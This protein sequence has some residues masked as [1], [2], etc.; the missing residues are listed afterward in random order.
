[1]TTNLRR[2]FRWAPNSS[3]K[4]LTFG[5][6][7]GWRRWSKNKQQLSRLANDAKAIDEHRDAK[8]AQLK[9]LIEQKVRHPER[10][11]QGEDNRKVVVFCAF[12]DTAA[13]LYE[14]LEGWARNPPPSA[15]NRGWL[16][17]GFEPPYGGIK[18]R[19]VT[20]RRRPKEP[21]GQWAPDRLTQ[22]RKR[23]PAGRLGR[24][25]RRARSRDP[26][27]A[28]RPRARPNGRRKRRRS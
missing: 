15:E 10:N 23:R 25:P 6:T 5:S 7:N 24:V 3:L 19:Y 16:G 13:Y 21:Q 9:E 1:M 2:C 8:L 12:A 17:G 14:E 27:H 28:P 4:C 18:I 11:T 20:G 26:P 22:R